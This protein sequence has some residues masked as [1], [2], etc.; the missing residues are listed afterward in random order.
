MTQEKFE[1]MR[2][3]EIE[4]ISAREFLS[5]ADCLRLVSAYRE[6]CAKPP[7]GDSV[8]CLQAYEA[9]EGV[10]AY[11]LAKLVL[12]SKPIGFCGITIFVVPHFSKVC[13]SVESLYLTPEY[14]KGTN[15]L[16]LLNWA[17][18][19]AKSLGAVGL[20]LTAV[21]GTRLE[22]IAFRLGKKTSHNF[23]LEV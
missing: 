6:E 10:K 13:A 4:E 12:N 11:H 3:S 21:E 9:M 15:G 18:R 19:K 8:P 2:I 23:F 7:F 1:T 20:T 16:R 14:R 17:K 22:Q 5:D